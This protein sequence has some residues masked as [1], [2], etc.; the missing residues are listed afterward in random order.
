MGGDGRIVVGTRGTGV[1]F[2][3]QIN[4]EGVTYVGELVDIKA[5]KSHEVAVGELQGGEPEAKETPE[6]AVFSSK[7]FEEGFIVLAFG[8]EDLGVEDLALLVDA[9]KDVQV[10]R[11]GVFVGSL[12]M[13]GLRFGTYVRGVFD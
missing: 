7:I 11:V 12:V 2:V 3:Y 13:A 6:A 8:G 10:F 1:V 5:S 9:E 4:G